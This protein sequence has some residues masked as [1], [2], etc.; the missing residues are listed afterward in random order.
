MSKFNL[1][2]QKNVIITPQTVCID[3]HEHMQVSESSEFKDFSRE[4]YKSLN[5]EYPK[6]YKMDRLCKLAFLAAELLVSDGSTKDIDLKKVAM[7]MENKSSTLNT[8]QKF[9]GTIEKIPSPAVFVY[10]LPN[11]A[12]GELAIR[13]KWTGENLF[14]IRDSFDASAFAE[15]IEM[16]FNSS[17]TEHCVCGWIEYATEEDFKVSMWIVSDTKEKTNRQFTVQELAA[18]FGM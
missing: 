8:D 1:Q 9:L 6:F 16:L 17:D 15:Q 7:F 2:I 4:L 18:D 13:H 10:T 14:L 12:I 5:C 11:I 3:G